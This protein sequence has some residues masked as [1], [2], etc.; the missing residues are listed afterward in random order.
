MRGDLMVRRPDEASDEA[1]SFFVLLGRHASEDSNA[2]LF[3]FLPDGEESGAIRMTRGELDRRARALAARLQARGLAGRQAL[4]IYPPGLEFIVAFFGCLYSRT[5]AVPAYPPRPNRPMTRLVTIVE[6][7]RPSVVL[8]CDSLQKDAARWSAGIPGLAGVEVLL[9]DEKDRD[10]WTGRW[11]APDVTGETLAFLQYTSGSTA[12]PKGVMITN[13]NLMANSARIHA[14]FGSVPG[15]RGVF[16]LP[17]FHDMGLIGGVLQTLYCGGASTLFPPASFLQRPLRWLQ[18][19]SRSGARIS[20]A[21][22]FAY[23]LCVE[24]T[25]PAQR[26]ELDLSC[27]SVAFNGAEPIRAET[28]ERFAEAF[29][30]AGFRHEAFL[31]CYGLAEATLFVSGTPAGRR[32]TVA[33]VDS[34]ALGRGDVVDPVTP[35]TAARLVSSGRP[36]ECHV[37][38]IVD[39]STG[40]PCTDGRVGEIWFSGSSVAQGYWNHTEETREAMGARLAG[41][42]DRTF[43]RTGDLGFLRDGELFVTGRLKDLIILRGRNIYPQDV[44]WAAEAS[45]PLLRAGGAAAFAVE[46]DGEERLA[47]VIEIER[48]L[49]A[50][51]ADEVL[52]A[53]RRSIAEVLDVEVSVIR[54]LKPTTL[55]RTSSGKVQRHACRERLLARTLETV[56]A[57]T[58]PTASEPPAREAAA[59]TPAPVRRS[60]PAAPSKSRHTITAWLAAKVAEPLG[61]RPDDVD[62]RAPLAGF[63]IGSLQ[64]VQVAAE[65]EERLGRKL[66]PTL[67][68]DYP[69]IDAIAGF[70]AGESSGA[71]PASET[72]A[73]PANDREPIAIIGMACRFPGASG[74]Y[75]FWE[76]LRGGVEAIGDVPDARWTDQDLHGLNFPRRSGFLRGIDLFDAAF[77][78]ITRR[79]AIFLDPQHRMLL[80]VAWEAL[81]DAGQAPD[82]LSGTPVGV[83]IGISTNDYAFVQVKRGGAAIGHGVTGNSGCIAANRISHFFDFRG[84]SLA[85]DTACSSSLVAAHLAC[86]SLWDGDAE[87]ALVGGS[88]LLLQTQIFAGFT[89][90]GFL[91]PDGHCR[92][93]D[94]QANGYVRGEGAGIVVLKPVSRALADGDAIYAIIRGGAINQDGRT[95]GLTAPSG[96]AQEA[97]LRASYRHAGVS[98]SQVDYVEAHGTGTPLGDPIELAALGSV[99]AERREPGRPCAIGSVKTNIGHL[100]AA[101][102]IAGLIKAALALHHRAIPASL[103]FSR[104]NPHVDLDALHLRIAVAFEAW[105]ATSE[106]A[107]AGVSAFGYGGTNAHIVLEEAPRP[108]TEQRRAGHP[109]DRSDEDVVI[110]LSARTPDALSELSR[111]FREFLCGASEDLDLR[112]VAYSAGARRGHLEHRL[113]LVVAGRD[114]AIGALGAY[115]RG[116]P[117]VSVVTGRRLAGL[118]RAP[119]FVFSEGGV[120]QRHLARELL[121]REQ[122]FRAALERCDACLA[123]ELGRSLIA[124]LENDMTS[125]PDAPEGQSPLRFA[126]QVALAGLWES[127]GVVPGACV[128]DGIGE[129]AA[130]HI[131]GRL[132]LE[133]AARIIG[134]REVTTAAGSTERFRG[135]LAN[136]AAEG[137]DVFIEIG[138]HPGLTATIQDAVAW[139]QGSPLVLSSPRGGKGSLESLRWSAAFLYAAGFDLGWARLSPPGR[140]IRLPSYPWRRERYWFDEEASLHAIGAREA[141]PIVEAQSQPPGANGQADGHV[142]ERVGSWDA[143]PPAPEANCHANGQ[144]DAT[145]GEPPRSI[146]ADDRPDELIGYLRDR[147]AGLLGLAPEKIETDRPLL[148]L[149]LDSIFAMELKLDLDAYLGVKLPLSALIEA[150]S[151]RDVAGQVQALLADSE[152]VGRGPSIQALQAAAPEVAPAGVRPSHGQQMLWYA[153]QFTP[154]G[155]AYHVAG[156]GSIRAGLDLDAARRALRRVIDRHEALRSTFPAVDEAPVVRVIGVDGFAAREDEWLLIEDAAAL[157]EGALSA[158]LSELVRR[159][160][161]LVAGP[162]FRIH[163]LGRSTG[164]HV[165]L[166][167]F[168]H[169][170]ADFLSVAV[171]LDDLGRAYAEERVGLARDWPALPV[172]HADFVRCQDEMLASDEGERLWSYWQRR[173]VGPLPVLDLPTDRPRPA[174][175]SDRGRTQHDALDP[176]LTG[177]L[178]ALAAAHGTTL[179]TVLLA[180][181]QV[182]LT[183]YAGQDEVIVGSPVAGRTRPGLEGLV[184][185]FVNMLPMRSSVADDP[186]F[187]EFLARVRRTVAEALE[188][189]DFPFSL[190]C[191]RVQG[192]LD[193]SRPP[194]FQV[195]YAHQRTPLLDEQGL[196]P[197]ALGVPGARLDLDGLTVES[198]A[199]DRQA[200]LFELTLMTARDGDRIRLAWEYSTDLFADEAIE[201]MAMGFHCLLEAVAGAPGRK[202]SDLPV[203]SPADRRWILEW[204]SPGPELKN[205]DTAIHHRFEREAAAAPKALALVFGEDSMSYGELNRLANIVARHLHSRG[206]GPESVVGLFLETWPLRLVGLLGVLKAGAAY[207]PLDPEHP[208][209]RLAAAFED[210]L[211]TILLADEPLRGRLPAFG[212]AKITLVDQLIGSSSGDDPGN[213]ESGAHGDN[214]AYIVFTSG[215]TGRPKGVMVSHRALVSVATAWERIYD[216][217]DSTRRHL[218]AAPFAFDVFTGDWVRA[219]TTGGTL[220]ACPRPASLDPAEL[221]RLIRRHEIDGLELVPALAEPLAEHLEAD[222]DGTPLSLRLLAIGSDSLRSGLLCRLLRLLAPG[223]RVVN[224]Y[225]LTEAAIDSACFDPGPDGESLLCG[226]APAPI[227][228]PLPGVRAFVLDRRLTPVP[229]GVVG[230]LYIGGSGVARGYVG[231]AART[232]ERFVPDPFGPPGARMYATGDRARW[233]DGG[234]LELLGRSDGQVKVRGVRIELG[235]VEAALA[236]HPAVKQAAVVAREDASGE[237]RL[238]AYFVP[239]GPA[240]VAEAELRRWLKDRLPDALVPSWL[241]ALAALPLSSNGKVDRLALPPP[242]EDGEVAASQEYA[243]PRTA[244]EEVLAGIAAGLLE[245]DDVGIHDNFFELGVD[246]IIG[247]RFVSRA[248]QAGIPLAPAQLFQTPTIAGLAAAVSGDARLADEPAIGTE[249]FDLM[250]RWLV[251]G[252]LERRL[253]A[254]GGIED[255]YPLSPVQQGMLFHTLVDPEAGHYVE[256]FVCGL[257][258]D[259]DRP[260]L[261]EAWRRLV[262]QHPA[263]RSTIH[264][265]DRDRPYQVVHR[266]VEPVLDYRD[267]R[268]LADSEQQERLAAFLA[269]DRRAGF[270]PSRPPLTRVALIRTSEDLHRLVWSIHHVAID[271]WCLSVLLHEALDTYEALR[272]GEEPNP[273]PTR[274]FRDYVAWL[275]GRGEGDAEVYWRRALRGI[276]EPTPLGLDGLTSYLPDG[277]AVDAGER[278]IALDPQVSS[279]LKELARSRRFTLSTL[280][281]GAWALLLARYS[282]WPEVVFGVTVSGRPPELPGVETIVGM[283]I[284]TLP[285]RVGVDESGHLVPWLLGLQ[286][287]LIELRRFEAVPLSRVQ[288]WSEVPPGR[289]LFESI[290]TVQNLPFVESL[291]DRANRLGVESPRYL[292]RTHYPITVTALPDTTLRIKI[293]FDAR[294]FAADAIER[295]L[296]HLQALLSSMADDP[297]VRLADLPW[298][299]DSEGESAP[300]QWGRPPDE[301]AWD[302][303]L[304]DLDR[305]DEGELDVLLDQFG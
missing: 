57:W 91:S 188:H 55:P 286:E 63:G 146:S 39:P 85:I 228:R 270:D 29:A 34:A 238:A 109:G 187:D 15:E 224:S 47:V 194:P 117:H 17:L 149:G 1:D 58:R 145:A 46:A 41:H 40:Q 158:R 280:I 80:E 183:R 140:F 184:G 220:V 50:G 301:A 160:F 26:A 14:V 197:F 195:M 230:E 112:D 202:L 295:V 266:R 38:A 54:L 215:T 251:R 200:A 192:S 176:G 304:P 31:P 111:S 191:D 250:P 129:V 303:D 143:A 72:P 217:R 70:L 35:S 67:V 88:N 186:P 99:L 7:A 261:H 56:A 264:W 132:G 33:S 279:A 244:V 212:S 289:P 64:A 284:N 232:A 216:L 62:I 275:L 81:E 256:Q 27:W 276:A 96:P 95:N 2:E 177:A 234:V 92:A 134:R 170:I 288:G 171:F 245:R 66:A 87:L 246:S 133:D 69:T 292:E 36:A 225:G 155:A 19:I 128:G 291:R 28:L 32:P 82:R 179:Y 139:D 6:D 43:L 180:A 22:N 118:R 175:R 294:R 259:L 25:T 136:L 277:E 196:A 173:L 153:H 282:G 71:A 5:V 137:H 241:I 148:A 283:F 169:I 163:L 127:W 221:A 185:C 11:V 102:G 21:P 115:L 189:Q 281:Q 302:I 231:D 97:V 240:G 68:Y 262:A 208:T 226:D 101:A 249:Q 198:V 59:P 207:L 130:L 116:E 107:R 209:E 49:P 248:R 273:S 122:A 290:V 233:R 253:G 125:R 106:P 213:P 93:F 206:A 4:L 257:R 142:N 236:R 297:E 141:A 305:L 20:G 13:G 51:S 271:G 16:W 9:S 23:D 298:T 100:E 10:E 110:P 104:P 247:I 3:S 123:R 44:E 223:A 119:V 37:V 105:P 242:C 78:G 287:G 272:R 121:R 150:A 235:E 114:E 211:A 161:D 243:P 84:P 214:L 53:V 126:V 60:T 18:A 61:I 239:A 181:F 131:A 24:N 229:P 151:I 299:L 222:R 120:I 144:R 285:L 218:Q 154:T 219:L 83:Y 293:G 172:R 89:K 147:V 52:T 168:H 258:G 267:W 156:A 76:L 79:E 263:L 268:E 164:E 269:S 199:L 237:K 74:P 42:D 182:F 205:E 265:G 210:S 86:K 278:E 167:A 138:A 204:W 260:A 30:P 45:H 77:F 73:A 152:M 8:T 48:R 90:S 162:L 255:V 178:A 159:P 193:P 124:E 12:A 252:D 65:L 98:P 174:V 227:G 203:L 300:R 135:D 108:A 296:G 75:A 274:P 165:V 103:N 190:I 94:A 166:L 113:A 201:Q 254:E 157:D